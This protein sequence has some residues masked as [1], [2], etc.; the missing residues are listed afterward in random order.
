[1]HGVAANAAPPRSIKA[2]PVI[3]VAS[4]SKRL[5]V[6]QFGVT[7]YHRL[8][9]VFYARSTTSGVKPNTCRVRCT[10]CWEPSFQCGQI[11]Q[12]CSAAFRLK[13]D[14]DPFFTAYD[15]GRSDSYR[16]LLYPMRTPSRWRRY[17]RW[18]TCG[19]PDPTIPTL[20]QISGE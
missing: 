4:T 16:N 15:F 2:M 8:G 3:M 5:R 10:I 9:C 17:G 11:A 13:A 18:G 1:S 7:R 12:R 20:T 6:A 19:R 14:V